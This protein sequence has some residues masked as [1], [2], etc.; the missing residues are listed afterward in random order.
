M[1]HQ[2]VEIDTN[3]LRSQIKQTYSE[4]ATDPYKPYHFITGRELAKWL[5]YS[6]EEVD[7]LPDSAVESFA[8]VHN[9]TVLHPIHS[10]E[11]LLDIGCGAG[12][13]SIISARS[14]GVNGR[15]MILWML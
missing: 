9:P 14:V 5:K 6:Q 4:V 8:G 15:V 13:D 12:F 2:P 3:E 7:S 11:T 1:T 10:G